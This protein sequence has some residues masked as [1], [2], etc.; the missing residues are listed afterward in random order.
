MCDN[1]EC[2]E[3]CITGKCAAYNARIASN[4]ETNQDFSDMVRLLATDKEAAKLYLYMCKRLS[5][6]GQISHLT[7]KLGKDMLSVISDID[8][9]KEQID[10]LISGLKVSLDALSGIKSELVKCQSFTDKIDNDL[11]SLEKKL[12]DLSSEETKA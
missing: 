6:A 5:S 4:M 1:L 10:E 12:D 11:N 7:D 8:K 3:G 9:K 2:S